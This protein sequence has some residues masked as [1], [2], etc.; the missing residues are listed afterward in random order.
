MKSIYLNYKTLSITRLIFILLLFCATVTLSTAQN[1]R[2]LAL[3]GI[4]ARITRSET[5]FA[6]QNNRVIRPERSSTEANEVIEVKTGSNLLKVNKVTSTAPVALYNRPAGT[7]IPSIIGNED[8]TYLGYNYTSQVFFG[9]AFSKPWEFRN[10]STGA[11]SYSWDWG[12]SIRYSTNQNLIIRT[13]YTDGTTE[14]FLNNGEYYAP[15]LNAINGTDTAKYEPAYS[16]TSESTY[17]TYLSASSGSQ[18]VSNAD[19]YGNTSQASMSGNYY[20]WMVAANST[21]LTGTGYGNLWGTCLRATDGANGTKVNSVINVYEKPMTPMV[22][23]DVC[24]WAATDLKVPVPINKFLT[25]TICRIN[26]AGQIT[27]DTLASSKIY[28]SDV[29]TDAYGDCYF[30]FSFVDI[31]PPTG[32]ELPLTLVVNDPFA[33]I[34][35]GCEQTGCNFGIFSD[36][37]NKID[38]TSFFTKV[39]AATGV[40]DG[41][42]YSATT[43]MNTFMMLN[44]YFN[45]L[46]AEPTTQT[47]TAPIA[48][49]EAVDKDNYSG[50]V[51]YSFFNL[52]NN[53]NFGD[54]I[55]VD[56][57]TLPSWL[58]I[59]HDNSEYAKYGALLFYSTATALPAGVTGRHADVVIKSF[60]AETTLHIVQGDVS[61]YATVQTT[62]SKVV[63]TNNSF[64]LTYPVEFSSVSIYGI[65]G[66][67]IANYDLP[68]GG[69]F[70]IPTTNIPKGIYI[71]RFSG[72]ETE[73]I[74]VIR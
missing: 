17:E 30:N 56:V 28:G 14:N 55:W 41:K 66:Q 32:R 18:Y 57:A 11:T 10:L 71:L 70:S 38:G 54:S 26:D 22:I 8:P 33:L 12:S 5:L 49:G 73:T 16:T 69:K 35:S 67:V 53:N 44:A 37:N 31:D 27:N 51:V 21:S 19:Y 2:S 65:S 39:D 34:L 4:H 52:T 46:Y 36:K 61:G 68:L 45:Y 6:K 29:I 23:K 60:G 24:I 3:R 43:N 15:K 20:W 47:L 42:L 48:G 13:E 59:T 50:S 1:R 72:R 74:K 7:Y 25:L 58:T 63:N 62:K 64:E 9:S 40:G